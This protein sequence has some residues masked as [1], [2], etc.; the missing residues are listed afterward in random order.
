MSKTSK[1]PMGAYKGHRTQ[2]VGGVHTLFSPTG[3][4][5]FTGVGAQGKLRA[6][7]DTLLAGPAKRNTGT[8]SHDADFKAGFLAGQSALK[9]R[10]DLSHLDSVKAHKG[11][12]GRHG[13]RWIEGYDAAINLARGAYDEPGPR[14]AKKFGLVK[15]GQSLRMNPAPTLKQLE[16]TFPNYDATNSPDY[17]EVW[18]Y[19]NGLNLPQDVA[20]NLTDKFNTRM[21]RKAG[22]HKHVRPMI[23]YHGSTNPRTRANHR[24][25]NPVKRLANHHI[26]V[27]TPVL[28]AGHVARVIAQHAKDY[29]TIKYVDTG[30]L[31]TVRG[32]TL[33]KK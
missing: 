5:T 18:A 4:K 17:E 15:N 25:K 32:S 11:L 28:S 20:D 16:S 19:L 3:P 33:N 23:E 6:H 30:S 1:N 22:H 26:A 9:V 21:W 12:R 29:Y 7:V 14:L 13:S 10:S 27:G 8:L 2:Q 24:Q 31:R